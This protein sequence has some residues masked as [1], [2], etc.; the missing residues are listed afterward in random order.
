[1]DYSQEEFKKIM[2]ELDAWVKKWNVDEKVYRYAWALSSP[3]KIREAMRKSEEYYK[4][5][6]PIINRKGEEEK[7]KMVIK[8]W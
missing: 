1:M 6:K 8:C 4:T 7:R 3:Q 2:S 5:H